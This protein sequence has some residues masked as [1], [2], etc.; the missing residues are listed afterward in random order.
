V[1]DEDFAGP[2]MVAANFSNGDGLTSCI[3]VG[4]TDDTVFEGPHSFTAEIERSTVGMLDTGMPNTTTV[5]ILD[6]EGIVTFI[7]VSRAS[8]HGC[9]NLTRD[10]IPLAWDMNSI[11]LYRG[12]YMAYY[13]IVIILLL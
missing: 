10:L 4:I 13:N 3:Q 6:R 2:S 5:E 8:V 12:Y 9:I 7:V 11:R 1:I